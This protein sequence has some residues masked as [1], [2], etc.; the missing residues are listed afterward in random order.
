MPRTTEDCVLIA[1]AGPAGLAAALFLDELGVNVELIDPHERA[2]DD[3]FA[4][5]LRRDTIGRL[6]AAGVV[7]D[8]LR[9]ARVLDAIHVYK[10]PRRSDEAPP[11]EALDGGAI[12]VP[13][14]T[15]NKR[16]AEA[17]KARGVKV[18]W[19]HRLARFDVADDRIYCDIDGLGID[20]AGY[21]T[22]THERI[23]ET[24]TR[25]EPTYLIGADG[26][27]SVVR[28]Q[29][30]APFPTIGATRRVL[31]FELDCGIDAGREAS[32][33]LG[34]A[35]VELWPLAATGVKVIVIDPRLPFH[36]PPDLSDL[37]A[38]V[39]FHAPGHLPP[40][41]K[42][43]RT[44]SE[45]IT[46]AR[47]ERPNFGRIWLLGGAARTLAPTPFAVDESIREAQRLATA[48]AHAIRTHDRPEMFVEHTI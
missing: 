3:D 26:G 20:T 22:M 46:P 23:V 42:L 12:T 45:E 41:A 7:F 21:G 2:P 40:I 47:A 9:E 10:G 8:P 4:V 32:V 17:L 16:I 39:D 43:R 11:I 44:R 19:S 18:K 34:D 38:L 25:R 24:T 14:Y 15:L 33:I 37:L 35:T 28:T 27:G 30:R 36:T 13:A 5:V 1:G 31:T 29:L 48:F 6:A